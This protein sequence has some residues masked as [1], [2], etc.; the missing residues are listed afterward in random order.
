M[1]AESKRVDG[2]RVAPAGRWISLALSA[3]E[4]T[5]TPSHLSISS[6]FFSVI[7]GGKY[8]RVEQCD[9]FQ[10]S[11]R[12]YSGIPMYFAQMIVFIVFWKCVTAPMSINLEISMSQNWRWW[13]VEVI[14]NQCYIIIK[15]R[16]N[17]IKY[18]S[19]RLFFITCKSVYNQ[20]YGL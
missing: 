5:H 20:Y 6:P 19:D 3:F 14:Q 10:C 1:E 11:I 2:T 8:Y 15:N 16:S 17:Y 18:L 9:R 4:W 12:L 7:F 13:K